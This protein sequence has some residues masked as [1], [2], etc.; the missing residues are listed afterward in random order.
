[1]HFMGRGA[2]ET[3][4]TIIGSIIALVVFTFAVGIPLHRCMIKNFTKLQQELVKHI[5]EILYLV[6]KYQYQFRL[7]KKA[8]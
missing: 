5:D 6:A 7:D 3:S 8:L 2:T 1:M 4:S